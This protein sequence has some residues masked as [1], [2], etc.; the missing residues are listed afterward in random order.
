MV[1]LILPPQ[2]HPHELIKSKFYRDSVL[3]KVERVF[4]N[5]ANASPSTDV[6]LCHIKQE[7]DEIKN[8]FNWL[9]DLCVE[10]MV[11]QLRSAHPPY[12]TQFDPPTQSTPRRWSP[13]SSLFQVEPQTSSSS[14]SEGNTMSSDFQ[15]SSPSIWDLNH[16]LKVPSNH[17]PQYPQA[18]KTPAFGIPSKEPSIMREPVHVLNQPL[19]NLSFGTKEASH[20]T[21][22]H[23]YHSAN[24][25]PLQQRNNPT[26]S[27]TY[28]SHREKDSLELHQPDHSSYN[29]FERYLPNKR[30]PALAPSPPQ[31]EPHPNPIHHQTQNWAEICKETHDGGP[32]VSSRQRKPINIKQTK[33]TNV[34]KASTN[35]RSAKSSEP[36][37]QPKSTDETLRRRV[38]I[39]NLPSD[40]S[41]SEIRNELEV[42]CG[43]IATTLW[44]A[45]RTDGK[46]YGS[47]LI[48]F[49]T[50]EG[51]EK[52]K[53]L[54]G[55]SL[56][57]RVIRIEP[58]RCT[59]P[60]KKK[61][62]GCQTVYLNNLSKSISESYLRELFQEC[63]E[64]KSVRLLE[65]ANRNTKSAFIEFLFTESTTLALQH[66]GK[67]IDCYPLHVDYQRSTGKSST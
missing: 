19:S 66:H 1:S 61:P 10:N 6:D 64:M 3:K 31:S 49:E 23:P 20:S 29:F 44:F 15:K 43:P 59:D 11:A 4:E 60:V 41:E 54:N 14:S 55:C 28:Q 17:S 30:Y 38:F 58:S 48:T 2:N 9:I 52:A 35:N 25:L 50:R 67:V 63:G 62:P 27:P 5:L 21:Q 7:A 46:F 24:H 39:S 32:P 8:E 34:T 36:K 51:A 13:S 56:F 42:T 37:S 33:K 65:R 53:S 47:G 40:F 22:N 26:P 57:G 12:P 18:G 45:S 16:N